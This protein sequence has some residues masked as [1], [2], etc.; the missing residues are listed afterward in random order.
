MPVTAIE[1]IV[2]NA[3][4]RLRGEITLAENTRVFVI[5]PDAQAIPSA[6]IRTPKLAN[7]RQSS[8]FRKQ[9]VEIPT[10]AQL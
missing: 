3:K 5:I 7:P 4:I 2:E 8:D 1:G 9:I 6:H 10:D